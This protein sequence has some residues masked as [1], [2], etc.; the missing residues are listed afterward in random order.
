MYLRPE[1]VAKYLKNRPDPA[2]APA[3]DAKDGKDG[4]GGKDG[5]AL[6]SAPPPAALEE[7]KAEEELLTK[8]PDG[9][10]ILGGFCT[11]PETNSKLQ[12]FQ[13]LQ[14]KCRTKLKKHVNGANLNGGLYWGFL[15][16][17]A[18]AGGGIFL[19]FIPEDK[20]LGGILSVIFGGLSLTGALVSG[21]GG[22]DGRQERHKMYAYRLD[23]YMWTLRIRIVSEVCN[24]K[25]V[26]IA[27]IKLKQI[28]NQ[29]GRMCGVHPDDGI[30]RPVD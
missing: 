24:A 21:L 28:Y 14:A 19:G 15:V 8:I 18:V 4:K 11:D 20:A 2:A 25:T 3:K 23:N 29:A 22:F 1:R 10:R 12:E 17:T 16:G 26:E 27:R 7:R 5:K 30:Y 13:A 6:K 9:D